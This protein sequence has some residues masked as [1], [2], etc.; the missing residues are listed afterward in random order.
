MVTV[1]S[2]PPIQ[3]GSAEGELLE[4]IRWSTYEAL[5]EDLD[6]GGRRIRLTSDCGRLETRRTRASGP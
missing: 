5:L 2:S 6:L 3:A 1:T 4:G